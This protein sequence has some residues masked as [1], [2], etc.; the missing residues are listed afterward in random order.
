MENHFDL[1]GPNGEKAVIY[2]QAARQ[3]RRI[4]LGLQVFN[5]ATQ[6][7]E[8]QL[9]TQLVPMDVVGITFEL[10]RLYEKAQDAG[11]RYPDCI[12]YEGRPPRRRWGC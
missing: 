7:F 10:W 12:R 9:A 8:K 4:E 1:L 5:Q 2:S 11:Y 3:G 6:L